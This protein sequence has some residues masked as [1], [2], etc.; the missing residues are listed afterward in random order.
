MSGE[1]HSEKAVHENSQYLE[2]AI[3][4]TEGVLISLDACLEFERKVREYKNELV[5]ELI[6][7]A[8]INDK[9]ISREGVKRASENLIPRKRGRL[10]RHLGSIGGILSGASLSA[11]LGMAIADKLSTLGILVSVAFCIVGVFMIAL[12][13]AKD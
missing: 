1:L 8:R 3:K 11:I 5:D 9:V 7:V 2:T 12:N 6:K 4:K 13:I 10:L